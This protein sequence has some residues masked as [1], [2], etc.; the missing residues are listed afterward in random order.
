MKY[1]L[2]LYKFGLTI[3]IIETS[4]RLFLFQAFHFKISNICKNRIKAK[5]K[6]DQN[7][8]KNKNNISM[9]WS[10]PSSSILSNRNLWNKEIKY[11]FNSHQKYR[12]IYVK[13]GLGAHKVKI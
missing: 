3:L 1:G 6:N 5:V 8:S 2:I 4:P 13:L 11:N 7:K 12:Y 10:T 9:T